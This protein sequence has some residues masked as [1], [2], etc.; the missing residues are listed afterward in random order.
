M[1]NQVLDV[2]ERKHLYIDGEWMLPHSTEVIE[3][4]DSVT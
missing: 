1:S 3:V 4:L 2:E